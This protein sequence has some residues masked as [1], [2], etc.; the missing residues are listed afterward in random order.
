[1]RSFRLTVLWL[2]VFGQ[3]IQLVFGAGH[4]P[5]LDESLITTNS[6]STGPT[7]EDGDVMRFS[8]GWREYDGTMSSVQCTPVNPPAACI[9]R[10]GLANLAT[11]NC[12]AVVLPESEGAVTFEPS[13]A[14]LSAINMPNTKSGTS[15]FNAFEAA[16]SKLAVVNDTL[17]AYTYNIAIDNF[18]G[19]AGRE[20]LHACFSVGNEHRRCV[21][22]ELQR[23][24]VW[25]QV[26]VLDAGPGFSR[27]RVPVHAFPF[28]TIL[29][30][31]QAR[32][33]NEMDRIEIVAENSA[34]NELGKAELAWFSYGGPTTC[35]E[36]LGGNNECVGGVWQRA[37][38][39]KPLD[40]VRSRTIR[41]TTRDMMG[42]KLS[43]DSSGMPN[44]AEISLNITR[45]SPSFLDELQL[46][47]SADGFGEAARGGP[48]DNYPGTPRQGALAGECPLGPGPDAEMERGAF[49]N[50]QVRMTFFSYMSGINQDNSSIQLALTGEIPEGVVQS[51]LAHESPLEQDLDPETEMAILF[52][53]SWDQL[54]PKEH[55][56]ASLF[57]QRPAKVAARNVHWTP[58]LGQ[59]GRTYPICMEAMDPRT[60]GKQTR[61]VMVHVSRCRYVTMEGDTL[62]SLSVKFKTTWLQLWSAN[63]GALLTTQVEAGTLLHLGPLYTVREKD[64]LDSLATR[65]HTEV[66]ESHHTKS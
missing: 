44:A 15:I 39:I 29:A 66:S 53:Q 49:V 20:D 61:C 8:C 10:A 57:G 25:I 51:T 6:E 64:S 9:Q 14:L 17:A 56:Y 19:F 4:D 42:N 13:D 2:G 28:Q 38:Y 58:R 22:I 5:Y 30:T 59:E 3:C 52:G 60:M 1:M 45:N 37:V 48:L 24:P 26:Q 27:T 55:P 21:K 35:V 65:F 62:Q 18:E 33:V 11:Y 34:G 31:I 7:P 47:I 12:F 32:D 41:F 16:T 50:C 36:P 43:L 54:Q 23:D 63:A 46:Q 40:E